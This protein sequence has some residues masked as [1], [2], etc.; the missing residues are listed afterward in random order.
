MRV[1]L[2]GPILALF[3]LT[4]AKWL[5]LKVKVLVTSCKFLHRIRD[6]APS[7]CRNRTAKKVEIFS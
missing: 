3:R 6:Q 7:T 1:R 2:I 4:V 5:S